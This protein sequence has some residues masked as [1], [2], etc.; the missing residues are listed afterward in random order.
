VKR[1]DALLLV[2]LSSIWGSSFLFIKLGVD[3]LEPSVVAFGRLFVGAL[4]LL[5]LLPGRG[6]LSPLRGHLVPIV[7][8]G[9][10]NNAVPFWLLGFAET[11]LDSGLT[12]VI[13]AAAPIF[14]VILASRIDATQRATGPRL[15]GVAIGFVGVALLVGVQTGGE[16]VAALAVLGVALCYASSVLYAG[17]TV[18]GI[19]PLQVSIG[20]L[21][22]AS[23]MLAPIALTQLPSSPPP[24]QTWLAVL[25]LGVLGSGI[26]YLLYF[27]IIASAGASRAILVTY[28]VPAFALVYGA[29]FLDEAVTAVAIAG[30]A[31]VL[32]GTALATGLARA[33]TASVGS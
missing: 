12:A 20:Q 25:A 21:G 30:L 2:L 19:P 13:Q 32:T 26:A 6:G 18:K 8:L 7:V 1:R 9:A 14:T 15:A 3:E 17:V 16:L 10:L 4:L 22:C 33:R 23:L 27:A 28:L 31:L 5:A 29:V 11:R 24:A